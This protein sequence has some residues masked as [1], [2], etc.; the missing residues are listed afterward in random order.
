MNTNQSIEEILSNLTF[1]TI[2]LN[3]GDTTKSIEAQALA[4]INRIIAAERIDELNSLITRLPADELGQQKYVLN[5]KA[6]GGILERIK[7]LDH[8]TK[9]GTQ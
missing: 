4:A 9:E 2:A 6:L 5:L 3:D 8:L 1:Q 7:E